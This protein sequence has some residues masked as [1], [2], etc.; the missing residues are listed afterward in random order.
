MRQG[1]RLNPSEFRII[2]AIG[3]QEADRLKEL[4]QYSQMI[5]ANPH[6]SIVEKQRRIASI[7]YNQK[8]DQ[9]VHQTDYS[10]QS[11]LS[12]ETY[13]RLINWIERRW[14]VEVAQHGITSAPGRAALASV[15]TYEIFATRYESKGGAYTAALPDKCV[16]FANGGLHTC[17]DFGYQAGGNYSIAISYKKGAAVTVGEAGPWNIDDTFW[18]SASDPTPRRM[19]ADL[20]IG[21]PEAQAA[22][23]NGYNGGLDQYGRKVTAPFAIDL[24]FQ[25]GDDIGLP[26]KKNDWITVSFLWTGEWGKTGSNSAKQ[27]GQTTD[28]APDEPSTSYN[29]IPL[30]ATVSPEVDGAINHIVRAGETLWAIALAYDVRVA[31]IQFLNNLGQKI[32][33][34]EGQRLIIKEAGPT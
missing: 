29:I 25:V 9:I 16:K 12:K 22:Y 26:P 3:E 20:A 21:M 31:Q 30:V 10:L 8:V 7:G 6:I 27:S 15:R 34:F 24:A 11:S 19:F 18:A 4:I 33:I 5:V 17:D 1:A 14:F 28:I 13:R 32:V 23:F 2:E